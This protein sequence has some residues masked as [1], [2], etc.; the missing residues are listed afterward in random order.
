MFSEVSSGMKHRIRSA[1]IVVKNDAVL[2]VKHKNTNSGSEWWV[3]PGGGLEDNESIFECAKRETYEE[4]GLTVELGQILYLRESV[5]LSRDI[6]QFEIFILANSFT[7]E[8]T[9]ANVR[10]QDLDSAYI[11]DVRFFSKHQMQGLT[12]FPEILKDKFWLDYSPGKKLEVQYLGQ[13]IE[14]SLIGE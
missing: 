10:P 11:K 7:G 4:T 3:P 6:H 5:D 8:L 14:K 9:I 12:V 1:A 13:Q 2:L